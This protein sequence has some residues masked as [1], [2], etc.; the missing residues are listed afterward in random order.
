MVLFI[1]EKC[2]FIFEALE[3]RGF[4]CFAV[5]GCVRDALMGNTPAD[6]D[7]TTDALPEEI[8][9]C[10]KDYTTIDIGKRFG[11]ICVISH[12]E[13]YEITTF[14][15]DGEYTDSRHPDSV[16]F[17]KTITEDLSRRDFTI[18]SMAYSPK[19]GIVDPFLGK[20][21]L[22]SKLIRCTG[23]AT[24]RFGEDALRMLRAVRFAS[25]LGF[26][27]ETKTAEAISRHKDSL[28][29][30]HP[31]RMRKEL[32]GILMGEHSHDV[33]MRYRDVIAVVIPEI[34]PMFDLPQ[35]NPHHKYDVWTHTLT[36]L[37]NSP[38]DETIRLAVFFH[39]IG[40][41]KM[42]TTD[43]GGIDH[44]KKH[45]LE[46]ERIARNILRRFAYPAD[47]VSDVCKL[48]RFHDERFKNLSPDIKRVLGEVGE[49][50]FIKLLEVS[51]ADILSQSDYRR[52]E[53]LL[54]HKKVLQE[55]YR[56]IDSD[57]C[58]KLSQLAL[59]GN[60]LMELGFR[61]EAIGHALDVLLRLVIKGKA[62]NT[63]ESLLFYANSLPHTSDD[64]N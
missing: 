56:I 62:E 24:E 36:A 10:F 30:V 7:F 50:L 57:E 34:K 51:R 28:S 22:E 54:H 32:T 20:E 18:N 12:G 45:Q 55:Y 31:Q 3:K 63:R 48:I 19:T 40:K 25:R 8:E 61:G 47:T 64:F 59:K 29:N 33:L 53:K 42:K 26:S 1:P 49:E 41:P 37:K 6:W 52:D 43:A 23:K 60:D 46:S 17:S 13:P 4:Q 39:D 27:L 44:F 9:E 38:Q 16:S 35:N 21:D 14:R 15:C 11:T 2:N 58:Y 5:G